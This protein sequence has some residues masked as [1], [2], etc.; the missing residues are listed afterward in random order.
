M[1]VMRAL[2]AA[3]LRAWRLTDTDRVTLDV[4]DRERGRLRDIV[5]LHGR[6]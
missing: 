5:C 2:G 6:G 4:I 3:C 1:R